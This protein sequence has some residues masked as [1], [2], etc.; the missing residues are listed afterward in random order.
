MHFPRWLDKIRPPGR[1]ELAQDYHPNPGKA[2]TGNEPSSRAK[3]RDLVVG[4]RVLRPGL[5]T[6][7]RSARDDGSL[8]QLSPEDDPGLDRI[9]R[10]NK[11][12][13]FALN[14]DM[15]H[16]RDAAKRIPLGR[17]CLKALG[18]L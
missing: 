15:M 5:S 13:P 2:E 6:A 16:D 7:L 10:E 14:I 17:E 18:K 3:S 9:E 1:G 12:Y 4:L 8:H 11:V